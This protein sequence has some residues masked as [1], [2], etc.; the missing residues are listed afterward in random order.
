MCTELL[1]GRE[2]AGDVQALYLEPLDVSEYD[3]L[4]LQETPSEKHWGK[5]NI[6]VMAPT[7]MHKESRP[8]LYV[9]GTVLNHESL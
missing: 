7:E 2:R 6:V 8:S 4:V 3:N 9:V 1:D 5:L